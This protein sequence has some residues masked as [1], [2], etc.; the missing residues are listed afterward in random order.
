M[1]RIIPVLALLFLASRCPDAAAARVTIDLNGVWEFEQTEK[2]FPPAQ[3]SRTIPVPGLIFL[4]EPRIEQWDAYYDG[5]YEPRCNW[6]RKSFHVPPELDGLEAVVT[7]RKSKYVTTVFLNG[8]KLGES[9]ACY[10]PVEFPAGDALRPGARNELLICVGDRKWLPSQA[11]G[12]TDK[13]K[14][15]YWPG[16]WDDVSLTFS[17]KLRIDRALVL[18]SLAGEKATL[19]LRLRSFHPA[20]IQYG[21]RMW[22]SCRVEVTVREKV[23]GKPVAGPVPLAANMKRDNLTFVELDVPLPSPTAWTPESPFLYVAEVVLLDAAGKVSDRVEQT[24]GMRDFARRGKHFTLNGEQTFLRGTN[25]TLHRF[26]EDPQCR[27]LPWDR[28]WVR[29]LLAGIPKEVHW[30]AMR[31]CVGLWPD[32]WYDIADSCGLMLQNEW[33][34]WQNHGWDDQIRAE[35]TDWVWSDGSHPSIVIWD[36]INENWDDYIGNELIPELKRLDPTR[37]WD[38]GYMTSEHMALDEMDEPHPYMVYGHRPD[39]AERIG[40]DP[41]PLGKL[42]YWPESMRRFLNSSAAQLVN[43]YGWVWLWRDGTPAILTRGNYAYYTGENSTVK[44]R[45]EHEA[46]W[47][48]AETEWLRA[49]RSFAGVL[50]F[51]YLTNDLGFTGDWFENP[52]SELRPTPA[53]KWFRHAF[54]PAAVF[55]DL[56]DQRWIRHV[57]P[58]EPGSTLALRLV[59]V[60]DN[61]VPVSGGVR[62]RLLDSA[63]VEAAGASLSITIPA[64]FREDRAVSLKLPDKPGGYLVLAEF[65]PE[66]RKEPVL[67]RRYVK[68]G[69]ADKYEF[70]EIAP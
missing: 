57:P 30:N 42:D 1:K 62:L 50:A 2:A 18:P 70:P 37:I 17:G 4:A 60:N 35:Y 52:V 33:L 28:D 22:D 12:S 8:R 23:G 27:A 31:V 36:A 14:V 46:Y 29:R 64:R 25:I 3:F 47:L 10:T 41:Y 39:F 53:L 63:G 67:S 34:Y 26:F 38:A 69:R 61:A 32:F 49:E 68:I 65:T 16:I 55:V 15:T 45:R 58:L 56:V 21:D 66:G 6:Y 5:S 40:K 24:F 44:E 13:E 59:G 9:M 51:C 43:E 20:Q 54:A 19:K 7:I 48:Q 11:A